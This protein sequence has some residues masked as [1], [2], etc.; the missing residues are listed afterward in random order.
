M[1]KYTSQAFRKYQVFPNPTLGDRST[2]LGKNDENKPKCWKI[3]SDGYPA[4]RLCAQRLPN[5]YHEFLK[6]L[7]LFEE[8]NF[9]IRADWNLYQKTGRNDPECRKQPNYPTS[10]SCSF[11]HRI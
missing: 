8:G 7:R 3:A 4:Y 11:L 1:E 2:E 10:G 5:P 6:S 9:V